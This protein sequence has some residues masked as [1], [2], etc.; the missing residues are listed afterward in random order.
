MRDFLISVVF[1]LLVETPLLYGQQNINPAENG[2]VMIKTL[3]NSDVQVI[4][5]AYLELERRWNQL[6]VAGVTPMGK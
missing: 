3:K 2:S 5:P 4:R 6:N 1:V